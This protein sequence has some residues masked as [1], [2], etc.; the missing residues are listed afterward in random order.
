M[1]DERALT[2]TIAVE[3]AAGKAALRDFSSVAEESAKK[4]ES[5]AKKVD[6]SLKRTG[7]ESKKHAFNFGEFFGKARDEVEKFGG[8]VGGKLGEVSD[9]FGQAATSA[10]SLASVGPG[11]GAI[12]PY[13]TALG[14]AVG[15][16]GFG[17][18]EIIKIGEK[19]GPVEHA[20]ES[21]TAAAGE[22]A[23]AYLSKM[24]PASHLLID[25]F[26]LMRTTN[27]ALLLGLHVTSDEM[28]KLTE[29]ALKLA[30]AQGEDG[31]RALDSFVESIGRATPRG[32]THYG[33]TVDLIKVETEYAASIG[34]TVEQLDKAEKQQALLNA[35]LTVGSERA[36]LLG[37]E[38]YTLS[39]AW[40]QFKVVLENVEEA[41]V[42]PLNEAL[43]Q[44]LLT[45]ITP[46]IVGVGILKDKFGEIK[47]PDVKDIDLWANAISASGKEGL[48][49][50][51]SGMKGA[52]ALDRLGV[53]ISKDTAHV[54]DLRAGVI[55]LRHML[56]EAPAGTDYFHAVSDALEKVQ[57]ELDAATGK[58]DKLTFSISELNRMSK[59]F[60]DA[61]AKGGPFGSSPLADQKAL[62]A[63]LSDRNAGVE[64]AKGF[65]SVNIEDDL[66]KQA[67]LEAKASD[68]LRQLRMEDSVEGSLEREASE[69]EIE[70]RKYE[71]LKAL[72]TAY[73]A[74]TA[75]VTDAHTLRVGKI[76]EKSE[77]ARQKIEA[78]HSKMR[79]QQ[80][81]AIFGQV[82]QLAEAA[83]G[84][85]K[86]G[87]IASAIA[88]TAQG[89]TAALSTQNYAGAALTAAIGAVQIAKI[90]STNFG[91]GGS[92]DSSAPSSAPS[93]NYSGA[94][95]TPGGGAGGNVTGTTPVV[96]GAPTSTTAAA[97]PSQ[98][99]VVI[100]AS[101]IDGKGIE[102][103]VSKP[104]VRRHIA[105]AVWLDN[106]GR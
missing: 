69:I 4:T 86:L 34:K 101:M 87:A 41:A 3:T 30:R 78:D 105:T 106:A 7:E 98:V 9:K 73:S 31:A 29:I 25:D 58:T 57:K 79:L 52:E 44:M 17:L 15:A 99:T 5:A 51:E 12:A 8:A 49:L 18:F 40:Q 56:D 75:A 10:S 97:T 26:N 24:I 82:G 65:G 72:Y 90:Q 32:L 14:A 46:L 33:V 35:V 84:Q 1:A 63:N 43:G 70:T 93:A 85:T 27:Q 95:G 39:T 53:S 50:A 94:V 23:D 61:G 21:L 91:G 68:D 47:A 92:G 38:V 22:N 100:N 102:E 62:N 20:F 89:V 16:L 2:L 77:K 42:K 96:A 103:L 28:A 45:K 64:G 81:S 71:Q 80:E 88:Y 67:E 76:H 11:I 55:Q 104:D 36:N 6:D 13:V 74:D 66:N 83:F 59:E 54:D 37:P 60:A 19:V 48:A